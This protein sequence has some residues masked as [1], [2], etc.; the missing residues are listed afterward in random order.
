MYFE[1]DDSKW[2]GERRASLDW[3]QRTIE[4]IARSVRCRG[5]MC[6]LRASAG[7]EEGGFTKSR[8]PRPTS[9]RFALALA[10]NI[11]LSAALHALHR[12]R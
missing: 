5:S 11:L 12:P 10:N 1:R 3:D 8:G 6:A 4:G 7:C 2:M 9:L